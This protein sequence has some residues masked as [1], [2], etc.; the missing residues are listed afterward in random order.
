MNKLVREKSKGTAKTSFQQ[1]VNKLLSKGQKYVIYTAINIRCN[2][3]Y[4]WKRYSFIYMTSKSKKY[5][6]IC[7]CI[8]VNSALVRGLATKIKTWGGS[9]PPPSASEFQANS[10]TCAK[11]GGSAVIM[12]TT[13]T[14]TKQKEDS[15]SGILYST[16]QYCRH[17]LQLTWL[18]NLSVIAPHSFSRGCKESTGPMY[19]VFCRVYPSTP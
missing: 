7:K 17:W 16:V 3:R 18:A 11:L 10:N 12:Y 4:I 6:F 14:E 9:P 1:T 19:Y 2:C 13:H 5:S 15:Q 8:K